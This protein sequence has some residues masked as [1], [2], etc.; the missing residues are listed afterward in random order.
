MKYVKI[1]PPILVLPGIAADPEKKQLER[2]ALYWSM[3]EGL[4]YVVDNAPTYQKPASMQRAGARLVRAFEHAAELGAAYAELKDEDWARLK[5]EIEGGETPWGSWFLQNDAQRSIPLKLSPRTFL[6]FTD[7]VA[8]ALG[9]E[10]FAKL[11]A[12]SRPEPS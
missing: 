8:E 10:S 3:L 11:G 2:P 5:D 9:D 1:V 6:P 4:T 12:E 7:A